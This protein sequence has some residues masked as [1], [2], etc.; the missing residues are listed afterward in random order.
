[1]IGVFWTAFVDREPEAHRANMLQVL[2]WCQEDRLKPHV[3][4]TY[5]LAGTMDALRVIQERKASGKVIVRP[6]E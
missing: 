1:M 2:S 4:G 6:Q 5:P 3:H